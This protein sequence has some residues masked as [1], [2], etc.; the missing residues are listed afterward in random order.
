[1]RRVGRVVSRPDAGRVEVELD[2]APACARCAEGR[3]CGAALFAPAHR[4]LSLICR[5]ECLL[6]DIGDRV[7]VEIGNRGS[8]WLQPVVLAYGL[9]TLGLLA[10]ACMP[11]PFTPLATIAGL[12]GGLLAGRIVSRSASVDSSLSRLDARIATV[13]PPYE[14]ALPD[15]SILSGDQS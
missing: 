4:P 1:M 13:H 15:P 5:S 3:G 12:A 6:P 7:T 14:S 10:G 9:P 8:G 2:P 11:E